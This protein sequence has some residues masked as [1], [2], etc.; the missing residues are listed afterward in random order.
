MTA[1]VLRAPASAGGVAPPPCCAP[2]RSESQTA[3]PWLPE[4]ARS[5]CLQPSPGQGQ[6]AASWPWAD[7]WPRAPGPPCP[8]PGSEDGQHLRPVDVEGTRGRDPPHGSTQL[9]AAAGHS[10]AV[11]VSCCFF[12]PRSQELSAAALAGKGDLWDH[13]RSTALKNRL[14]LALTPDDVQGRQAGSV[15]RRNAGHTALR[16][17]S[18]LASPSISSGP[19]LPRGPRWGGLRLTQRSTSRTRHGPARPGFCGGPRFN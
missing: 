4:A 3:R 1:K 10:A 5:A 17:G 11:T 7:G 18:A 8:H 12:Q 2:R 19:P 9:S 15:P 14:F 6:L 16:P 13:V